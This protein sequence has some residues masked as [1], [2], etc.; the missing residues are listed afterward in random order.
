ME[1]LRRTPRRT[2]LIVTVVLIFVGELVAV[3]DVTD[4]ESGHTS[5][6]DWIGGLVVALIASLIA[7]GLLLRFVPGTESEAD[8]DNKPARRGLVL[9]VV[10]LVTVVV[11]WA[12]LPFAF[13]VPALVLAAEGRA[14]SATY[15]REAEATAAAVIAAFAVVA[16]VVLDIVG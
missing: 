5:T 3:A 4:N 11:F 1:V 10:A 9:A 16:A 13:G 14:R 2:I 7:A 8:D 15:G 6:G 12:G